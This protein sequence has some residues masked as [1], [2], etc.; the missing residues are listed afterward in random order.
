MCLQNEKLLTME[1]IR[2]AV[3]VDLIKKELTPEKFL[4]KTNKA[5]NE[6]YIVTAHD[7]PNTMIEIA[8]LR[9]LSFRTAG[10]G[11]GKSIDIDE[12][13]TMENPFKQLIVWDPKEEK[14]L[15]GYRF[16]FGK[17]VRFDEN[18][19][20]LLAT[21]Y[22][23]KFSQKFIKEYLPYTMELG[24]SFV[25]PDYQSSKM[26]SKSLFAL[27]NLW[28]G[29]GALTV[30]IPE[31]KYLFGKVTIYSQY[32][33]NARDM[34]LGFVDNTFPDE[35]KLVEPINPIK[36]QY[37]KQQIQEL[38]AADSIKE[39]YK[40][41]NTE[42][43]AL[44][45]N[46]PPLVNAYIGLSPTIKSFGASRFLEFGDVIEFGILVNIADIYKEKKNR[47]IESY[48]KFLAEKNI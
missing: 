27:D 45:V 6:I 26:G 12:Y 14:I 19:T 25:Q 4:R 29:I 24:R 21:A 20:P 8:R 46:I 40:K 7:S 31:M 30:K 15:G 41:L 34:I 13:D 38:F 47:H 11:T 36:N 1:A 33:E 18:G 10:G 9:E 2:E 22:E 28:D 35:E 43:R 48:L 37:T 32:N 23:F 16:L 39:S 5:D 42:V 17:D 44:G 3:A